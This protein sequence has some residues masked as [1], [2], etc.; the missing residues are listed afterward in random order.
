MADFIEYIRDTVTLPFGWGPPELAHFRKAG[1]FDGLDACRAFHDIFAR[2]LSPSDK[3]DPFSL[4]MSILI[5]L[6]LDVEHVH[7]A[8]K[9][10]QQE[11]LI[12]TCLARAVLNHYMNTEQI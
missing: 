12:V 1:R 2:R 11:G 10:A 5:P 4:S 8:L 9:D 7:E 3:E 6:M